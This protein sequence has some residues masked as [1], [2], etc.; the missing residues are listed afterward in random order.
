MVEVVLTKHAKKRTKER[1]GLNKSTLQKEATKAF[2]KGLNHR[3]L[4]GSVKKLF[5]ALYFKYQTANNIKLYSNYLY[6]FKGNILLTVYPVPQPY[7]KKAEKL[8]KNGL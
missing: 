1:L 6:I 5:D 7:R 3:E 2:E 8:C 4:K